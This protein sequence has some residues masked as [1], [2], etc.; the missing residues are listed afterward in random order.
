MQ[1]D[2][3]KPQ[4]IP[5]IEIKEEINKDKNVNYKFELTTAAS[6]LLSSIKDK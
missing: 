1:A 6:I 4:A 3:Q 2:L 5:F